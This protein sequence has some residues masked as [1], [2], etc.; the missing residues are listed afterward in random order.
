MSRQFWEETLFWAT[1]DGTAVSNT[2]TETIVFPNVTIPGG[3]MQ[4]GRCLRLK[5]WG[6]YSNVVTA[7]PTFAWKVRWGGVAGTVLVQTPAMTASVLAVT[8]APWEIEVYLQTRSNGSSGTVFGMGKTVMYTGI[9]TEFLNNTTTLTTTA[10]SDIAGPMSSTGTTVPAA[11][12]VDLTVDTALSVSCVMS[13]ANASNGFTG[14]LY[15][16]EALN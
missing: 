6:R 12:T 16:V 13:A 11:V 5:A 3:M 7:V 14:H 9:T 10:F 2:T 4:D 8:S 1:A 15:T